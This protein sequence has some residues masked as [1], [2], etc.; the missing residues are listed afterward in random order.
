MPSTPG[1]S[2][3]RILVLIKGLGIGGAERLIAE[4]ATFWDRSAYTYRVAYIVPWKDQ[5]VPDL[6]SQGIDVS[7]VGGAR[8]GPVTSTIRL[9]SLVADWKPRLIHAHLPYS[10]ILAR[11]IGPPVVY[12]E[13][14]MVDSYRWATRAINR[15]TY[16]RNAA[17][18][19]VSGEVARSIRR[20]PGRKAVIIPNGI[21]FEPG[22][23]HR[24]EVRSELGLDTDDELVVHVGNIRPHK[25]HSNLIA[26]TAILGPLRPSVHVISI[27][28][29][30]Y[31][32]DLIRVRLEAEEAGASQ[33][34][35]FLGRKGDARSY[36]ASA[37]VVVNPSDAEGLPV[38]ILEAMSHARKVVAT[39]VGGVSSVV[40]DGLTGRLVPPGDPKALARALLEALSGN[41][42]WGEAG[43]ALV[44]E[45]HGIEQMVARYETL[46]RQV[47]DG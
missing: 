39:D 42:D 5:L 46:Y 18:T 1:N 12:T 10:G 28:G 7:C 15:M 22:I 19:A 27:G 16:G 40:I 35:R 47:L 3:D 21:T 37:D 32:G 30:K 25:G 13:H 26:A 36:I 24:H 29:E 23:R 6:E 20:Y 38:T 45:R 41:Q 17:V 2:S 34:I 43:S 9:R 4:S 11:F 31:D 44:R 33:W 8:G 14:N